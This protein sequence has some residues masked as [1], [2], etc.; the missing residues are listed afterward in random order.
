[1]A[2]RVWG[3]AGKDVDQSVQTSSCQMNT[4]WEP[5]VQHGEYSHPYGIMYLETAKRGNLKHPPHEKEMAV[6]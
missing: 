6:R 2:P 1:M 4:F 3:E 5:N